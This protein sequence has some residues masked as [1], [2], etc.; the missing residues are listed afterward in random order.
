MKLTR[1]VPIARIRQGVRLV[2]E[3]DTT[4]SGAIARETIF[5]LDQVKALLLDGR[6][7]TDG[8]LLLLMAYRHRLET[9]RLLA[10]RGR[11]TETQAVS[12]LRR[13][14]TWQQKRTGSRSASTS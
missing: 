3:M 8:A 2:L 9:V 4:A 10:Q 11:I 13:G 1:R 5:Q 12:F 6:I 14:K 7:D